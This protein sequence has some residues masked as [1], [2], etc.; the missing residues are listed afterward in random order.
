MKTSKSSLRILIPLF[1]AA[2]LVITT[3]YRMVYPF[4]PAFRDGLGVSFESISRA[5]AGRSFAAA[6]GPFVASL[7]DSR[8]RKTGMLFGLALFFGGTAVVVFWPAFPGFVLALVLT[9]LGKFAFDPAMQAYLGDRVPYERRG[10]ALTLTEFSWSGSFVFGIPLMGWLIARQGWIAPF[11]LLGILALVFVALFSLILPKDEE[12]ESKARPSMW[13][14]L[15][16]VFGSSTALLGLRFTF[17]SS[18]A[19]EMINLVFGVWM[20]A[21]FQLQ[22]T[23]LGAAAAVIGIAEIGG[24]GLVAVFVDRIGKRRAILLGLILNSFAALLLPLLGRSLPGAVLGLFLFYV[25]FEFA[26]V[27]SI[28][29]M[30]EILPKARATMMAVIITSSSLGRAIAGLIAPALYSLG[31]SANTLSSIFLNLIAFIALSQIR[32]ASAE[33]PNK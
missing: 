10:L 26:V 28:P 12:A 6:L 22:L 15:R 5:I 2:R 18:A 14:N 11:P 31:I 29:L 27:S 7:A 1:T 8:G 4:L 24:E 32:V 9:G 13:K 25:T 20:E 21:S 16:T 3:A 23:A 19:Y 30:T 17:F 33:K